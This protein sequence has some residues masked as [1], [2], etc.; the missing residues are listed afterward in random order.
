LAANSGTSI[1]GDAKPPAKLTKTEVEEWIPTC[2]P[3]WICG[4]YFFTFKAVLQLLDIT[5]III[6]QHAS[7]AIIY[8]DCF[9][10]TI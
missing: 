3:L 1:E 10:L 7:D 4:D 9:T 6:K 5:L 8:H 2:C